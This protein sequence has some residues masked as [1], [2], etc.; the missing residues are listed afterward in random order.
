MYKVF[1]GNRYLAFYSE[2]EI[3]KNDHNQSIILCKNKKSF[4]IAYN[5]FEKDEQILYLNLICSN[6]DVIFKHFSKKFKTIKA[7]GGLVVNASDET[8]VIK[9]NGMWDLPKGKL[10]K[11]EKKRDAA[12]REVEEEC[13]I[14]G[15]TVEYRIGKSYHTYF[16]ENKPILKITYWYKMAYN[17]KKTPVPQ[18]EEGITEI[19]WIKK[20]E[21]SEIAELAY[22]NLKNIFEVQLNS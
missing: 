11:N 4:D 18:T 16:M 10:E 14:H 17:G 1:F 22:P 13:G 20:A 6:P 9:R 15:F 7:A 5:E 21:L 8:L 2:N 12:I 3:Q 19:V